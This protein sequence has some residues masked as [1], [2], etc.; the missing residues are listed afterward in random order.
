MPLLVDAYNVLHVVGVLPPDLAGIDL[1]E[2][3]DLIAGSRYRRESTILVCDGTKKPHRVDHP[4]IHVTFAGPGV[5][6]DDHIIRLVQRSSAP[7]RLTVVTSDREIARDARRR[8]AIVVTSEAFLARLAEDRHHPPPAE[9]SRHRRSSDHP[10]DRRQVEHWLR[11]FGIAA[12]DP[13]LE[14]PPSEAPKTPPRKS[15]N[16]PDLGDHDRS[17]PGKPSRKR[18]PE[19]LEARKLADIDPD[20]VDGIDMDR[21]IDESGRLRGPAGD[22]SENPGH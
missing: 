8:R 13:S 22:E 18:R 2:L 20:Q 5:K 14:M 7:R 4:G 11:V 12:D 3:A 16:Q 17:T 15:G 19:I 9:S 1:P 10:A 6:A 21:L